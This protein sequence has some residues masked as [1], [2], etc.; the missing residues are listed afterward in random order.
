MVHKEH[1]GYGN[2]IPKDHC[3]RMADCVDKCRF[4]SWVEALNDDVDSP[5]DVASEEHGELTDN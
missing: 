1:V 4:T 3:N 5:C 2:D